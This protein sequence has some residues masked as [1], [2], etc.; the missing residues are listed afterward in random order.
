MENTQNI[1]D[2]YRNGD[3]AQRLFMYMEYRDL[4]EEFMDIEQAE[5]VVNPVPCVQAPVAGQSVIRRWI[6]W[7]RSPFAGVC[8]PTADS[9]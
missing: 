7:L 5:S 2:D 9:R 8:C 4:R 3:M 1:L 6:A